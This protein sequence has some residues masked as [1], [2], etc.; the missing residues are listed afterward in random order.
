MVRE[1]ES[2]GVWLVATMGME[3]WDPITFNGQ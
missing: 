1:D 3:L 2:K